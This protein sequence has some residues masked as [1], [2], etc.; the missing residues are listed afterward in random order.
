MKKAILY[1][2]LILMTLQTGFSQTVVKMNLPQQAK[3]ALKVV[4]LFDEE[5][6]GG[7]T[8][9]LGLMGYQLNGGLSPYTYEWYQN[10]K[11]IG[12]NDIVSLVPANGDQVTL[13]VKDKNRCYSQSSVNMKVRGIKPEGTEDVSGGINVFPTLV[14]NQQ[15][16]IKLPALKP[17][18]EAL[19]RFM[20]LNAKVL[21]SKN[22][23]ESQ[24]L[25]FDLPSGSYF[26]SVR[27]GEFQLV[28]KIVVND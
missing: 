22:I 2:S 14:T 21:I 23:R 10:S 6:P 18:D 1:L 3:E 24:T 13:K 12:T 25:H 20:D 16:Q 19:I 15:I 17:N 27:T 5:V 26:V 8:V 4:V 11:L 9:V 28:K 7:M